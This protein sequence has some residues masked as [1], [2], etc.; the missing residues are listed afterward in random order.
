MIV[1]LIRNNIDG[2]GYVGQSTYCFSVRYGKGT[3]RAWWKY[4]DNKY[5]KRAIAK[6]GHENFEVTLLASNL[7]SEDD[8]DKVEKFYIEKLGTVSPKGYNYT[9]GGQVVR[10]AWFDQDKCDEL[11]I[12]SSG[13]SK[14]EL[15]NNRTGKIHEFVNVSR[16]ARE[17]KL[18]GSS[19][20]RLLSGDY[21]QYGDWT[22]PDKPKRRFEIYHKDGEKH[23]VLDGDVGKFCKQVGISQG[24]LFATTAGKASHTHGWVAKI[25]T[26]QPCEVDSLVWSPI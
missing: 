15:L 5:L 11:A 4:V 22:V 24:N 25:F 7:V 13:K 12:R 14:R 16:F 6:H 1:Y 8:L 17:N 3:K 23:I 18:D 26:P 9:S 10:G 19:L 21:L 2:K 20:S